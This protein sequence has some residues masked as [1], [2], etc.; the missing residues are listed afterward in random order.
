[1]QRN[2]DLIDHPKY[3][4]VST[5]WGSQQGNVDDIDYKHGHHT[6]TAAIDQYDSLLRHHLFFLFF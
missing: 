4:I 1:M 2:D 5:D 6:Y 3:W